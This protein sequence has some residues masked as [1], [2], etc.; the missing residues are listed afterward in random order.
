MPPHTT[1]Y[2]EDE[3]VLFVDDDDDDDHAGAGWTHPEAIPTAVTPITLLGADFIL[4]IYVFS[5]SAS[6][7]LDE[8]F[9]I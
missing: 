8:P 5:I 7:C 2:G 6:I 1:R 9:Y 4:S 3:G